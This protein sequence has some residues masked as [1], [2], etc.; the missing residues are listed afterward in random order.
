MYCLLQQLPP[1]IFRAKAARSQLSRC[2]ESFTTQSV[3]GVTLKRAILTPCCVGIIDLGAHSKICLTHLS[4][5]VA[6]R[7]GVAGDAGAFLLVSLRL[8]PAAATA[9]GGSCSLE[10]VVQQHEQ[11][12]IVW[13]GSSHGCR[14]RH[15]YSK[16]LT[17]FNI[18]WVDKKAH[19][20]VSFGS[21]ECLP[22]SLPNAFFQPL[23]LRK[24]SRRTKKF[25]SHLVRC[26]AVRLHVY[27]VR[28]S[29]TGGT[30]DFANP[31]VR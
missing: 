14:R 30:Q 24:S 15:P 10:I 5:E 20:A 7:A 19:T 29:N 31:L 28:T 27:F 3:F 26:R 1:V 6:P 11:A 9:V 23:S 13:T 25:G 12:R 18:L 16:C 22:A 21:I 17:A 8:F 4:G 2:G